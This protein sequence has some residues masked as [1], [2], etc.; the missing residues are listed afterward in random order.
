MVG[1]GILHTRRREPA[2]A[3]VATFLLALFVV[4]GR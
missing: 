1:A 3:A 2:A 4:V